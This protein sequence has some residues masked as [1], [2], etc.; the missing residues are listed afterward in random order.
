MMFGQNMAKHTSGKNYKLLQEVTH[1]TEGEVQNEQRIAAR[2]DVNPSYTL[3]TSFSEILDMFEF[4]D[5][6]T[7]RF[8]G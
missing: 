4:V 5:F 8:V 3:E 7:L 2:V 1:W 6:D